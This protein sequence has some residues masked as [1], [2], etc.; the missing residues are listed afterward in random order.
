[1]SSNHAK[2]HYS[3]TCSTHDKTV[4]HCL[5]AIAQCVE[6]AEFPQI[7]WGGT[8]AAAWKKNNGQFTIRFTAPSYRATYIA[9]ANKLLDKHWTLIT[10]NDNDPASP[11]R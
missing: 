6:G 5:R 1:M 10:T 9:E 11:Q 7:G 3:A 8:T 4:L 2:Y